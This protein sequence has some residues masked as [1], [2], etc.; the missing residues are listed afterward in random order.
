VKDALKI[1]RKE[2]LTYVR[3]DRFWLMVFLPLVIMPLLMHLPLLLMGHFLQ[4]A[5][6]RPQ[7]VAIKG[8]S[9]EVQILLRQ[10]NL[11]V[12]SSPDPRKAVRERLAAVGLI[13]SEG[14]YTIFDQ[15]S[16]LS[17][18][19]S[20]ATEQTRQVLQRYKE[21]VLLEGWAWQTSSPSPSRP[22]RRPVNES[23]PWAYWHSS[24]PLCWWVC[25]SREDRP[26]PS[27]PR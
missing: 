2:L 6:S 24:F 27:R 9:Q 5:Q 1:A 20:A 19:L 17:L 8:V 12:Q 3:E 25:L 13:Y 14:R 21:Q 23:S 11:V 15:N 16:F 4:Q 26:W 22:R 10:A 7:I 18:R